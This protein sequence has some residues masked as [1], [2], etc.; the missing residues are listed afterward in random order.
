M[1]ETGFFGTKAPLFMDIVTLI[2]ILLPFLLFGS[3]ALAMKKQFAL[4]KLTQVTLFIV[5]V[6]VVLFFEYGVRI[7]GGIEKYLTYTEISDSFVI[8]FLVFHITIAMV[9][10]FLWARLLYLSF[11]ASKAGELPGKFSLYHKK[12]AKA[13]TIAILLTGIT[14]FGVYYILFM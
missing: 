1:F 4:H 13:T 3:I 14:G 7:D 12:F 8:S 2:V 6:I 11:K 5:T 10:I 9:A